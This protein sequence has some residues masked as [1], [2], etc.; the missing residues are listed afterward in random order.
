MT[1]EGVPAPI[2]VEANGLTFSVVDAGTGP[3]VLLLHGFPDSHRLWRHQVPA[4]V[5]AGFRVIAPDLRGFGESSRPEGVE[6]YAMGHI[7]EDV[8]GILRA[9]GVPL[10]HVVGHDWGAG[11]AWVLA[12]TNP[13]LVD[14]LVAI[15]VGHPAAFSRQTM[16]QAEKSWYMLLFQFPGIAERLLPKD[17]WRWLRE[18]TRDGADV[19]RYV[20]DLSR[21]GA[22]TAGLN[23]YRANIPPD[24]VLMDPPPFPP[25]D[26]RVLGIWGEHDPFLTE[27]Q[28][29][30]SADQVSGSWRYERVA[31]TGCRSTSPRSSAGC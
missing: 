18:W 9:L 20:A 25:V 22:L 2:E 27:G 6:A 11:V 31:A 21:P 30:A 19:E 13:Q 3:G 12:M 16:E 17:G 5:A 4:L 14:R 24:R 8:R 29:T 23:W 15:S 26:K 28:M 7:V 1:E 10:A